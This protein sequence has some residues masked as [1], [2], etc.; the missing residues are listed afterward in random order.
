MDIRKRI[1][2]IDQEIN[3][4]KGVR[5]GLLMVMDE[6]RSTILGPLAIP[7]E[8]SSLN[9]RPPA[10]KTPVEREDTKPAR[11]ER[12]RST[13]DLLERFCGYL[14]KH[15]K[16]ALLESA[17][18]DLKCDKRQLSNLVCRNRDLFARPALGMYCM[19]EDGPA[20]T[21]VDQVCGDRS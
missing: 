16:G 18:T 1:D 8:L 6:N 7:A 21:D 10:S 13:G 19:K 4:K 17:V 15:P 3:Y 9:I 14:R 20:G 5:D 11:K 12:S 2:E